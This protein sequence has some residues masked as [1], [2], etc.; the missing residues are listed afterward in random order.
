MSY[1]NQI[2]NLI[3]EYRIKLLWPARNSLKKIMEESKSMVTSV[4]TS[5]KNKLSDQDYETVKDLAIKNLKK[6][7]TQNLTT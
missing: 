2:K 6:H 4:P 5:L 1:L 3:D 7:Y